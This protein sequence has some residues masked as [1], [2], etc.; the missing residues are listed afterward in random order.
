[1]T[2]IREGESEPQARFRDSRFFHS[3]D[4][5]FFITREETIEGPF[6]HKAEAEQKLET[7]IEEMA[8]A[9]GQN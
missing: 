1:M 9:W 7:Y 4:E 8:R 5:W 2:F 6:E 3:M